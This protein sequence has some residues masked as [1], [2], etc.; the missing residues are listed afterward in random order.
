MKVLFLDVDGVL[1]DLEWIKANA[2]KPSFQATIDDLVQQ[3]DPDRV[4]RINDIVSRTGC[5][6]VLSSSTRVDPRMSVV[7]AKAGLKYPIHSATPVLL[8]RTN[9]DGT[10]YEPIKR[11][12]E[13]LDWLWQANDIEKYVILDDQDF[14][15]ASFIFDGSPLSNSWVQTS[16]TGNG[17]TEE[18]KERVIN[19][20]L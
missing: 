17:L 1:N 2:P 16:F 9:I 6:I 3:I 13:V 18:I 15:W 20:L 7:L 12:E 5:E 11:A 8:W 10:Q 4:N 14:E 19:L